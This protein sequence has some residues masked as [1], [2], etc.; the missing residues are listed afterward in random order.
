VLKQER[1]TKWEAAAEVSRSRLHS[2]YED[3]VRLEVA[4]LQAPQP[5]PQQLASAPTIAQRLASIYAPA[6]VVTELASYLATQ[7]PPAATRPLEWWR[8][9][10]HQYPTLATL[11]RQYL[12]VPASTAEVERLFSQAGLQMT[13][14]R[15]RMAADLL[16]DLLIIKVNK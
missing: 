3:A 15:N 9:N 6:Q 4:R 16:E 5:A 8:E 10:A 7:Q 2:E 11:A 14:R 1:A 12:A 13:D